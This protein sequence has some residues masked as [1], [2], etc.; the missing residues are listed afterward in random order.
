MMDNHMVLLALPYILQGAAGAVGGNIAGMIRR[1]ETWGPLF[2]TLLGAGGGLIAAQALHAVG[3]AQ[4]G[5][6]LLGGNLAALES[7][8]AVM[9]GATIALVSSA[10][11]QPD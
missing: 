11:K 5:A 7:G 1:T 10:F 6:A 4:A 8:L 3:Q 2:N 9:G